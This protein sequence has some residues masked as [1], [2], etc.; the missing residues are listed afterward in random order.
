MIELFILISCISAVIGFIGYGIFTGQEYA[1][2]EYLHIKMHR[3]SPIRKILFMR[4]CMC[5]GIFS[6]VVALDGGYKGL[7]FW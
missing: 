1:D 5:F 7:R 6:L 4:F 3:C 2:S